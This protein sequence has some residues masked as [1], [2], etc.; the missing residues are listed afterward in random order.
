MTFS[1]QQLTKRTITTATT[2]WS[3]ESW[4]VL[5]F[6]SL[7]DH[8][9]LIFR[10]DATRKCKFC[11]LAN[12]KTRGPGKARG[13]EPTRALVWLGVCEIGPMSRACNIGSPIS[14][15][16]AAAALLVYFMLLVYATVRPEC[17]K[18]A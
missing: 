1:P 17:N 13:R 7:D 4:Q 6:K 11:S 15:G 9:L 18:F 3:D 16:S 8:S 5:L 2:L 12:L 14:A 10:L